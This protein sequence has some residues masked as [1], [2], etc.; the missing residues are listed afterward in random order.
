MTL[1]TTWGGAGDRP[2]EDTQGIYTGRVAASREAE[3]LC[4][5]P[6]TA[7]CGPSPPPYWGQANGQLSG[8]QQYKSGLGTAHLNQET[9]GQRSPQ[10]AQHPSP[11]A[12]LA[13]SSHTPRGARGKR[14]PSSAS[15][16]AGWSRTL[17][18]RLI[19]THTGA[20]PSTPTLSK[21]GCRLEALTVWKCIIRREAMNSLCLVN[22]LTEFI[23]QDLGRFREQCSVTGF[24]ASPE[25]GGRG[26]WST[27]SPSLPQAGAREHR[28][29]EAFLPRP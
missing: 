20:C 12:W 6:P 9:D 23:L 5:C 18:R 25:Q 29:W 8:F 15:W 27:G 19:P 14:P 21:R 3:T 1:G 17:L 24:L 22:P 2:L 13:I 4:L 7:K 11:K 26:E 10:S 28:Q 16:A